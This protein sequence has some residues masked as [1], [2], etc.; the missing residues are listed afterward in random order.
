M[1]VLYYMEM[2][3]FVTTDNAR[4]P[5]PRQRQKAEAPTTPMSQN[6]AQSSPICQKKV[7]Q[8]HKG[9]PGSRGFHGFAVSG[10]GESVGSGGSKICDKRRF[11]DIVCDK[12]RWT[13][14]I[15]R[16]RVA[17]PFF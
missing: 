10:R 8:C 4:R 12:I 11:C 1:R 14:V 3:G 17:T 7:S 13:E 9:I 16:E 2:G 15:N 6:V 5:R